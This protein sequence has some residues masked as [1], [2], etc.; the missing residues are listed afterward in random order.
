M[1]RHQSSHCSQFMWGAEQQP[2]CFI[3][4][5]DKIGRA[6]YGVHIMG[7]HTMRECAQYEI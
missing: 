6:H 3:F 2:A 5:N 1:L 7:V 4:S